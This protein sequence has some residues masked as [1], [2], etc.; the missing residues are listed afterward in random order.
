MRMSVAL[1]TGFALAL[2]QPVLAQAQGE[3][4][5]ADAPGVQATSPAPA[6]ELP[7]EA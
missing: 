5:P 1:I 2:L 3:G 6:T 4:A 7:N